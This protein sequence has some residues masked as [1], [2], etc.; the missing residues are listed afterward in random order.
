MILQ[1]ITNKRIKREREREITYNNNESLSHIQASMLGSQSDK[2]EDNLVSGTDGG[3]RIASFCPHDVST[4]VAS[5]KPLHKPGVHQLARGAP[6]V[7]LMVADNVCIKGHL[8]QKLEKDT[9]LG[10]RYIGN[11]T[12]LHDS[13]R[14][15][16][17][18]RRVHKERWGQGNISR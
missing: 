16:M 18:A 4:E 17:R 14:T 3:T 9:P 5:V 13:I 10:V 15:Q 11:A 1:W 8:L 2:R 6:D 7:Q 12:A